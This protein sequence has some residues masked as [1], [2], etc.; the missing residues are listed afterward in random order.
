MKTGRNV[1]VPKPTQMKQN[2]RR[3]IDTL[4]YQPTVDERLNFNQ[5][6]QSG[7]ELSDV[8]TSKKRPANISEKVKDHFAG[9]WLIW[10]LGALAAG[11]LYLISDSKVA[12]TKFETMLSTQNEKLNDLKNTEAEIQKNDR[13]QDLKI[14]ENSILLNQIKDD[15][16]LTETKVEKLMNSQQ[17]H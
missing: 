17:K 12:F 13:S 14:Q 4:D 5:T 1:H 6:S 15:V 10:F 9:N 8:E 3:Y 11:I 2:Y 16:S 7:E